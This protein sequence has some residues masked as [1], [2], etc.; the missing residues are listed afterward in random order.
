MRPTPPQKYLIKPHA[1]FEMHRRQITEVQVL[2]VL[3]NP[4]QIIQKDGGRCV[5]QA[6]LRVEDK[7]FL[8]R[9]V[10]DTQFEPAEVVTVYRTSLRMRQDELELV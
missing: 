9:V 7:E 6:K 4:G 8:F 1:R 10:V 2:R 3:T 5:Y